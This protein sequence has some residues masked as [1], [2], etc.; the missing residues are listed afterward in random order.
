MPAVYIGSMKNAMKVAL[1]LGLALTLGLSTLAAANADVI[2]RPLDFSTK[3]TPS[4]PV[5][6]YAG[7]YLGTLHL[8]V[9]NDGTVSGWYRAQDAGPVQ[10]VVG[11]LDGDSIWFDI[12]NQTVVPRDNGTTELSGPLQV[13]GTLKHGR[14]EGSVDSGFSRLAFT[15][16]Q[17][18][19]PQQSE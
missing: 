5:T 6:D 16:Q 11:G 2:G 7:A 17:Q 18:T 19:S 8:N 15:A 13:I 1:G 9:A 10:P 14:L 4:F 12:G 3:M